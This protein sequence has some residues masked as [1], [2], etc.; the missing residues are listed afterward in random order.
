MKVK[1]LR[2]FRNEIFIYVDIVAGILDLSTNGILDSFWEEDKNN[3]YY[4]YTDQLTNLRQFLTDQGYWAEVKKAD[5]I[6]TVSGRGHG[7]PEKFEL[8]W[9]KIFENYKDMRKKGILKGSKE[10]LRYDE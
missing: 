8:F 4:Y 6:Y 10:P 3:N 9:N 7:I 5:E 2:A 1:A